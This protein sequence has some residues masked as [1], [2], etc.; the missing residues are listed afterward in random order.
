MDQQEGQLN[1]FGITFALRFQ[2]ITI[3]VSR[4]PDPYNWFKLA[5][6]ITPV[7]SDLAVSAAAIATI[8]DNNQ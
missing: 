3:V 4:N 1:L 6:V 8:S 5:S 2:V 7:L